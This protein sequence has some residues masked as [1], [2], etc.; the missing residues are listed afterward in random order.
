MR[1]FKTQEGLTAETLC[2]AQPGPADLDRNPR[3]NTQG[4]VALD[5]KVA[6]GGFFDARGYVVPE[7]IGVEK[8]EQGN[9]CQHA[10]AHKRGDQNQ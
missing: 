7:V 9:R 3:K 8:Q 1:F 5:D 2:I 6:A 4:Q 10:N